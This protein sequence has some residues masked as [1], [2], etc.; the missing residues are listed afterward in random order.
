MCAQSFAGRKTIQ[1][2]TEPHP[3]GTR[4]DSNYIKLLVQIKNNEVHH[5]TDF[6]IKCLALTAALILSPHPS[7]SENN[8]KIPEN[9]FMTLAKVFNFC[10]NVYR[11]GIGFDL[12]FHKK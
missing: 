11:V 3:T 8:T 4:N 1:A 7:A 2:H 5:I 10:Y 6:S 12:N 9:C